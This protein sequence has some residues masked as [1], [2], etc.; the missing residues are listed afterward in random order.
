MVDVMEGGLCKANS[1]M[2]TILTS[3]TAF[4]GRPQNRSIFLL[5]FAL[6]TYIF[7]FAIE[8]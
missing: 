1:K 8:G 5:H 4:V 6:R 7:G 2:T 3:T